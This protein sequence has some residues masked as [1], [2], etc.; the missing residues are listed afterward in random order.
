MKASALTRPTTT[1]NR[2]RILRHAWAAFRV[3]D[4]ILFRNTPMGQWDV[5]KGVVQ[6]RAHE[7]HM[8]GA[9]AG[10]YKRSYLVLHGCPST[11]RQ[12]QEGQ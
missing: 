3:A 9:M 2:H 6:C 5:A 4:V 8:V 7:L 11:D 12:S 1:T 10:S